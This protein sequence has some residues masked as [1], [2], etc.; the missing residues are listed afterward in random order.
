MIRP[1]LIVNASFAMQ[2]FLCSCYRRLR[3]VLLQLFSSLF[4]IMLNK[5]VG[6]RLQFGIVKSF[7]FNCSKQGSPC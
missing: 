4:V 1:C 2:A 7:S 5:K 3:S 6:V